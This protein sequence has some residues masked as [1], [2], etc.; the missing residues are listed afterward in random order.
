MYQTGK[1]KLL[2]FSLKQARSYMVRCSRGEGTGAGFTA[3]C[4][5]VV[6]MSQTGFGRPWSARSDLTTMAP[7]GNR[8]SLVGTSGFG[9]SNPPEQHACIIINVCFCWPILTSLK[10]ETDDFSFFPSSVKYCL[11][12]SCTCDVDK[13]STSSVLSMN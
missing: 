12:Q 9:Q 2:H 7:G 13:L 4:H 8:Q 11:S 10:S 1:S 6:V 5:A 3:L